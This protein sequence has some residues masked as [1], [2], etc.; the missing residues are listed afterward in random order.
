M[1]NPFSITHKPESTLHNA[2]SGYS[3]ASA[4]DRNSADA[5]SQALPSS[6]ANRLDALRSPSPDSSSLSSYAQLMSSSGVSSSQFKQSSGATIEIVTQDGD[7]IELS[8][9]SRMQ[10]SF[11]E[12]FTQ[13]P[14]QSTYSAELSTSSV[15]SFDFKVQGQLDAGEQRAIETLM[16]D[17]GEMA[18]EFFRGDVQGAFNA[19]Q[20]LGFDSSELKSLAVDMQQ[21]TQ[22]KVV[23]TY[24]Q[25][26]KMFSPGNLRTDRAESSPGPAPALNVL[27][28]LEQLL[29]EVQQ[30]DLLESPEKL[31]K[32]LLNELFETY[33]ET[34][35]FP[36]KDYIEKLVQ[37]F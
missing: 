35:E 11:S 7:R 17:I 5:Q 32:N 9:A 23:E 28:Q 20:N 12:Q 27:S 4:Q 36:V 18:S 37:Q 33:E 25:T 31:V 16:Q 3:L 8:Y 30:S 34:F 1:D 14:Q 21:K 22:A 13:N 19:A 24:Q 10:Y 2:G 15:V 29:N 6:M 26:E